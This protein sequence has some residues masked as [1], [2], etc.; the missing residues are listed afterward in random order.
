MNGGGGRGRNGFK[1]RGREERGAEGE[2]VQADEESLVQEA[3]DEEDVLV[4][5]DK[6]LVTQ[7]VVKVSWKGKYLVGVV[8]VQEEGT[9]LVNV[10]VGGVAAAKGKGGVHVHV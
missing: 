4:K 5:E 1:K 7:F 8:E 2:E 9:G 10:L 6:M 3:G